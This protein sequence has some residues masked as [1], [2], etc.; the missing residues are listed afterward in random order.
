M[1]RL[2][3][4]K[5]PADRPRAG[6]AEQA[7]RRSCSGGPAD[8]L[9]CRGA[10]RR[11]LG[12]GRDRRGAERQCGPQRGGAAA[13]RNDRRS[14]AAR[15]PGG[16]SGACAGRHDRSGGAEGHRVREAD[17]EVA[18]VVRHERS[19][20]ARPAE[21]ARR[22]NLGPGFIVRGRSA[23]VLRAGAVVFRL[24]RSCASELEGDGLGGA[25]GLCVVVLVAPA[26]K[27]K[28]R[29]APGRS[30]GRTSGETAAA[31]GEGE[32]R[33]RR[34]EE[35]TAPEPA[36]EEGRDDG[37]RHE[38]RPRRTQDREVRGVWGLWSVD[39]GRRCC[40]AS[41]RGSDGSRRA[42]R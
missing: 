32:A 1:Q 30:R 37:A 9:P 26:R 20:P 23:G 3:P 14:G 18:C 19:N 29:G 21:E 11:A 6:T 17:L 39:S 28:P 41:L 38:R 5:T 16:W 33:I 22:S 8:R 31:A 34:S 12:L 42:A 10:E 40:C 13:G 35:Q 25:C 4:R 15:R 36:A 2:F 27:A 7:A 24:A